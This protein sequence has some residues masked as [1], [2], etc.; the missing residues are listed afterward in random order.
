VVAELV[1]D[2]VDRLVLAGEFGG[3][4]V[5]E[6]V[7]VDPLVDPGPAG[8]AGEPLYARAVLEELP[9][10]ALLDPDVPLPCPRSSLSARLNAFESL[11]M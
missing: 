9:A 10:D 1:A 2:E 3:V 11:L 8:Q 6:P 7:G 5:A 4:G